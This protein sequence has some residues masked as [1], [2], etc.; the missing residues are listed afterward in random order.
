MLLLAQQ[1]IPP[2]P[3][4]DSVYW[5]LLLSRILHI[6]G[7]IVL[8][9]G[10]F[11]IRAVLATAGTTNSST[12]D[13]TAEQADRFFGGRRAAWAMWV[14][15]ATFILLATGLW[16]YLQMIWRHE[17]LEFPY[18]MLAGIKIL[19]ALTLFVLAPLLAGRTAAADTLRRNFRLWL[20]VAILLGIVTVALGSVLRTLPR[21]LKVDAQPPA[22]FIAP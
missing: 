9:G 4:L 11:Y 1:P 22:Q 18:H 5:I 10:L 19:T 2:G 20:N 15:I 14:G 13:A 21:T 12:G 17:R 7:A 3:T 8:V 6:L 16:N